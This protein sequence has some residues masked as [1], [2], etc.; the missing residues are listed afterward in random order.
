MTLTGWEGG[1]A[2]MQLRA[3]AWDYEDSGSQ[4]RIVQHFHHTHLTYLSDYGK[5]R[6]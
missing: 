2:I 3:A 4:G 6:P 1:L 5:F